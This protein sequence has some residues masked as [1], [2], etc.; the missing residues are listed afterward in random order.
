MI[1]IRITS[2]HPP[3]IPR[4]GTDQQPCHRCDQ[5]DQGHDVE[6]DTTAVD[7][8]AEDIAAKAVS[9]E[10]MPFGSDGLEPVR[11]ILRIGVMGR[12]DGRA[13]GD[14]H[15]ETRMPRPNIAIVFDRKFSQPL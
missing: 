13:K 9:A 6:R 8:T 14:Q 2:A 12:D 10:E 3:E 15:Q 5:G 11:Q 7:Q 4:Y 1:R